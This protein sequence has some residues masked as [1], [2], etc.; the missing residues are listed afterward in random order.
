MRT[1]GQPPRA[2]DAPASSQLGGDV[3][4]ALLPTW[5]AADALPAAPCRQ[6]GQRQSLHVWVSNVVPGWRF[7]APSNSNNNSSSNMLLTHPPL[8]VGDAHDDGQ[9][10]VN[11]LQLTLQ[12]G[13]RLLPRVCVWERKGGDKR[14]CVGRCVSKERSA[15]RHQAPRGVRTQRR[16]VE[17]LAHHRWQA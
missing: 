14:V 8:L 5:A 15:S 12:R 16:G 9:L 3:L 17:N 2:N 11:R 7:T 10:L 13:H 4:L 6:Q 1:L